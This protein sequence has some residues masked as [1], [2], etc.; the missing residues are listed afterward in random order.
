MEEFI[1]DA[2]LQVNVWVENSRAKED[3]WRRKRIVLREV[4]F[5]F[6]MTIFVRG[7]L[8]THDL[9]ENVSRILTTLL[10]IDTN[11]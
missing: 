3:M 11:H 7:A 10:R 4:Q 6:E 8:G 5:N 1:A 9:G 2:T